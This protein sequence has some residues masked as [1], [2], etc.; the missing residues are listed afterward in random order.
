MKKFAILC[1]LASL[2]ADNF[3]AAP[4]AYKS[5]FKRQRASLHT[6]KSQIFVAADW[7][8]STQLKAL[9]EVCHKAKWLSAHGPRFPP[10]IRS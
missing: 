2:L 3:V 5:K 10:L 4:N 1:R 6:D 9:V 7:E 8:K